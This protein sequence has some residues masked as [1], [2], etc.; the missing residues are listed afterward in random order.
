M[1]ASKENGYT[2]AVT[3]LLSTYK[4]LIVDEHLADKITSEQMAEPVWL[5][6][7]ML[8]NADDVC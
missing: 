2:R 8:G 6:I 1:T 3:D 7:L 4:V 5:D